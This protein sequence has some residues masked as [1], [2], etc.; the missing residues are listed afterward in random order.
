MSLPNMNRI[1]SPTIDPFPLRY[2]KQRSEPNAPQ[3]TEAGRCSA[4]P[5]RARESPGHQECPQSTDHRCT[6]SGSTHRKV[7]DTAM[8]RVR[9]LGGSIR[10]LGRRL[11]TPPTDH[12]PPALPPPPRR[13]SS[14][15]LPGFDNL[16]T[17]RPQNFSV[18]N[19]NIPVLVEYSSQP[20]GR[21]QRRD[22]IRSSGV[23]YLST[24]P[25]DNR[26]S[27]IVRARATAVGYDNLF[28]T[29]I[30]TKDE[31][32]DLWVCWNQGSSDD[33]VDRNIVKN[34]GFRRVVELMASRGWRDKF[35][36]NYRAAR[37][38]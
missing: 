5:S 24:N 12:A 13:L 21:M 10:S 2:G 26:D 19:P 33:R 15:Q 8:S 20:S 7:S 3:E 23:V 36:L 1:D 30:G 29:N 4:E 17:L 14:S 11:I 16:S 25:L 31:F 37:R 34:E 9:S 27:F 38:N 6:E 22:R 32:L 35:V 28:D 18:W